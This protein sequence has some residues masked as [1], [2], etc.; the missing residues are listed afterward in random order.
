MKGPAQTQGSPAN[1]LGS[2]SSESLGEMAQNMGG[3][4]GGSQQ[5]SAQQMQ[6]LQQQAGISE[7]QKSREVG[8]IGEELVKRPLA[9][10]AK[11]IRSIF[12]ID[13]LLGQESSQP[14][15]EEQAK[16]K[17]LHQR[18]NQ[19]SGEE[20][21]VARERYQREMERKQ[22]MAEEDEM[23]RQQEAQKSVV[24]MPSS[25]QKGPAGPGG[26]K[27]QQAMQQLQDDRTK[28]GKVQGAN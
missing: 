2:L 24:Q 10:I 28:I 12:S 11:G 23:R 7:D 6:A 25:P 18:F 5:P 17:Q 20:Q 13:N 3:S 14:G 4:S 27:K 15:P 19:L 22:R 8:T 9:D 1:G 16:K 26:S 21:A